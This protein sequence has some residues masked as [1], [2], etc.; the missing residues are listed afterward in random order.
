M[1]YGRTLTELAQEIERQNNAKRDYLVDTTQL[2]MGLDVT[3]EVRLDIADSAHTFGLNEV[4]HQQIGQQMGIPLPYYRRMLSDAPGL[5][6]TN[7][8][9]WMRNRNEDAKERRRMVRTLDNTARA[10]LSDRYRR[11]DNYEIANIVLPI[12]GEIKDVQIASCEVT[13]RKLYIKA[14]NPRLQ[15]DVTPGDVVQSGVCITN[16]EVGLG[17]FEATPLVYRL[18][19]SNGM[20]VN[21]AAQKRRHI[22]AKAQQGE[23]YALYADETIAADDR[24]FMLKVRDTVRSIVDATQ[25]DKVVAMMQEAREAKITAESIPAFVELTAKEYAIGKKES[26]SVL[27]YLIHGGDL[28]LYGLSNAVTRFSQDV[29]SY[30]RASELESIG[31]DVL[32]M[33]AKKWKQLNH[34][35]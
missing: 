24:A 11:I 9:H 33:P 15:A 27:S 10:F 13:D 7:V 28:S 19:C 18:V 30:D 31:Y 3:G 25:F 8:N 12:L 14:V 26:E 32:S 16:S 29:P 20:V 35:A 6:A 22:G 5:L 1:K 34:S 23:D 4:A 21:D 17:S 2:T